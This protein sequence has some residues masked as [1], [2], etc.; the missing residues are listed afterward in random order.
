MRN[1]FI[2]KSN[3]E[4]KTETNNELN[5]IFSNDNNSN[6][7]NQIGKNNE[8]KNF[9][10]IKNKSQNDKDLIDIDFSGKNTIQINQ[11]SNINITVVQNNPTQNVANEGKKGFSFVK[12]KKTEVENE[13]K[14]D[15]NI[16][17]FDL[18]NIIPD[19]TNDG[20]NKNNKETLNPQ[21]NEI[22]Q[23]NSVNKTFNI[24]DLLSTLTTNNDINSIPNLGSNNNQNSNNNYYNQYNNEQFRYNNI[25]NQNSYNN[26]PNYSLNYSNDFKSLNYNETTTKDNSKSNLKE[27]EKNAFSFI[28]DL[29]KINK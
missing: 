1:R 23:S 7:N 16:D 11:T 27:K 5:D 10:F 25:N 3:V 8:K 26:N 29:I 13:K 17:I 28:D 9:S 14:L 24:D 2:K 15:N 22:L 4:S 20:L 21:V 19:L 18:N 12:T 6:T